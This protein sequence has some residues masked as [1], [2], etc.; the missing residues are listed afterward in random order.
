MPKTKALSLGVEWQEISATAADWDKTGKKQCLKML[1]HMHLIRAFEEELLELDREGQVHGPLHVSVG[2][3]GSMVA[4][5]SMLGAGDLVNG[6]HRGHHLFL[7]KSLNYLET[8]DFDPVKD[9]YPEDIRTLIYRTMAEILGLSPGYCKG[10]GGSMHL[11]WDEAGVVGTNA[12]V[13]GGVPLAN[14][15]AWSKKRDG[16][17]EI[18]L[19]SFG[20][21]SC[22]IGNVLESL[23][24]AAL[25]DLP[26][27]FYIENNGYAVSTTLAEQARET[28]MSSRGLGFGMPAY[29]VDG[30][31]P[32]SVRVAMEKVAKLLREGKG[33]AM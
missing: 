33:P 8:L 3:E 2:Q 28:R 29:R 6:S 11:R 5:M 31:N 18:V 12:I 14:G 30:L 19:T 21:G 23:N 10:R 27:C 32:M 4:A 17:N 25:Y 7:A 20:D 26:I 24:L 1:N 16:N 22:H 15:A 9:S 13:G